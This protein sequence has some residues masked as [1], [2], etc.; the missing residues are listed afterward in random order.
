MRPRVGSSSSIW[1]GISCTAGA[2]RVLRRV[3]WT[4]HTGSQ[5]I[6]SG[7]CT[8]QIAFAGRLQKFEPIAGADPDKI[9]GQILGRGIPGRV[10]EPE[11][12]KARAEDDDRDTSL[13]PYSHHARSSLGFVKC[14]T[15]NRI[16]MREL[17]DVRYR[18]SMR[19]SR[20]IAP[21]FATQMITRMRSASFSSRSTACSP[22]QRY[23]SRQ[24]KVFK[25][26]MREDAAADGKLRV[27]VSYSRKDEAFAQEL[28]AG[29]ERDQCQTC[30]T[31]LTSHSARIKN[32]N[33]G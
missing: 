10:P 32:W 14:S 9:A 31:L 17:V 29:L 18:T 5:R 6:N 13:P 3:A 26:P 4:V 2:L 27:F 20:A 24:K 33:L 15:L 12:F 16:A 8:S 21:A 28:V 19:N 23:S 11:S 30:L 22:V 7:I 1:T 25:F